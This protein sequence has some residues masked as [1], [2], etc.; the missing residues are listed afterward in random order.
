[1]MIKQVWH[2]YI[3]L[4]DDGFQCGI[5]DDA[6][7]SVKQAYAKYLQEEADRKQNNIKL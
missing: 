1:M 4:D 2:D 5:R 6:P 3:I 7:E